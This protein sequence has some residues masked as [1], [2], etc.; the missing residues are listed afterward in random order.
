MLQKQVP[1]NSE[2]TSISETGAS[3][4]ETSTHWMELFKNFTISFLIYKMK[5]HKRFIFKIMFKKS[6]F[7]K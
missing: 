2:I 5:S 6:Y 4:L 7:L 1:R 3:I